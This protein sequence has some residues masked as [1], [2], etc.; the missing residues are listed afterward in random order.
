MDIA[1]LPNSLQR[2]TFG[3]CFD[4]WLAELDLWRLPLPSRLQSLAFGGRFDQNVDNVAL[5]SGLHNLT[6]GHHF[7]RSMDNMALPGGLQ[8]LT[9]GGCFDQTMDNVF[10]PTALRN[11]TFGDNVGKVLVASILASAS[12]LPFSSLACLPPIPWWSATSWL[13]YAY[14]YS[15]GPGQASLFLR[16]SSCLGRCGCI[17]P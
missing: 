3:A 6:F 4:H 13:E 14:V 7:D 11:G 10:L 2:L 15:L 17:E 5:P 12:S 9:F 1:A 8:S 16:A